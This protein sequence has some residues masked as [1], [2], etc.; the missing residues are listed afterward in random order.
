VYQV[1]GVANAL[2]AFKSA[3]STAPAEVAKQLEAWR[4]RLT[5][6]TQ[7]NKP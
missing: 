2:N 3:G 5:D 4:E 7:G 1:L 6:G